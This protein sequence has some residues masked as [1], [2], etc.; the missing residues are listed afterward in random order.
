M[1]SSSINIGINQLGK[2]LVEKIDLHFKNH[3]TDFHENYV[4]SASIESQKDNL[5]FSVIKEGEYPIS[6]CE[7]IKT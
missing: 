5:Q 1:P 6:D 2:K 4:L 3:E 7:N